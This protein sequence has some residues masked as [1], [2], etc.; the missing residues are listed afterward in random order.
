[1]DQLQDEQNDEEMRQNTGSRNGNKQMNPLLQV[2]LVPRFLSRCS[3][4]SKSTLLSLKA[5]VEA[6]FVCCFDS[7]IGW[8][9]FARQCFFTIRPPLFALLLLRSSV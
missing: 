2:W 1:M 9:F 3:S 5:P 4:G 8:S 7:F 6:L